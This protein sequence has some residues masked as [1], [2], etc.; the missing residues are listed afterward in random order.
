MVQLI[1]GSGGH[2]LGNTKIDS[3]TAWPS[4]PMKTAGAIFLRLVGAA[5]GQQ[6]TGLSWEFRNKSG[7][8]LRSGSTTC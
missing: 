8:V 4:S 7:T 1:A 2:T 3:R 6:A 5:N